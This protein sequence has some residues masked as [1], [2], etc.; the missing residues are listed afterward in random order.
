MQ[1]V[2]EPALPEVWYSPERAFRCRRRLFNL[3][4]RPHGLLGSYPV[5]WHADDEP[6]KG[7]PGNRGDRSLSDSEWAQVGDLNREGKGN[8]RSLGSRISP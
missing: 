5:V 6:Q 8:R 1:A 7:K 4:G 2:R 3:A